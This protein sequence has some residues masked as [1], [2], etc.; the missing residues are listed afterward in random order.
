MI[1][2][3][4]RYSV[5]FRDGPVAYEVTLFGTPDEVTRE[6]AEEIAQALDERVRG[7]PLP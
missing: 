5:Y 7:A 4:A 3:D 1:H 2:P 6:Q